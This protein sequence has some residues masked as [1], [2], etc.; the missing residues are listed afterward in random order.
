MKSI[1]LKAL[2]A[3][4]AVLACHTATAQTDSVI[5][6]TITHRYERFYY[7]SWYDT[8]PFFL[9]SHMILYPTL[10]I[11]PIGNKFYTPQPIAVKGLA[12]M[13]MRE[14]DLPPVS[15]YRYS[16]DHGHLPEYLSLWQDSSYYA[17]LA[18]DSLRVDTVIPRVMRIPLSGR[19]SSRYALCHLYEV[20]FD[21]PVIVDSF[22]YVGGSGYSNK[23]VPNDSHTDVGPYYKRWQYATVMDVEGL[24]I[25]NIDN[26]C[27]NQSP[28]YN[29]ITVIGGPSR[30]PW[31]RRWGPFFAIA[32]FYN[33]NVESSNVSWGSADGGGRYSD[34]TTVTITATP[35][36]GYRF[37]RWNDGNTR[38][39]RTVFLTQDTHFIA[40][41]TDSIPF[42]LTANP[43]RQYNGQVT[44]GGEFWYGD[45]ATLTAIPA[46]NHRFLYWNDG[47]TANPRTV[48]VTQ[49]TLFTAYFEWI[50]QHEGITAPDGQLSIL[51]SQFSITPNP[52]RNSVTVTINPQLSILNSQLSMTLTDAAGRELLNTKVSTLNFQLPISQYPAGTYFVTLRTPDAS[53]TQRLV[54]K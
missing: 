7:Y 53:S 13:V 38:N 34:Q 54:I 20:F 22:F 3:V 8:C 35:E 2:I 6:D 33:I 37:R 25:E 32:D 5:H 19:N 12:A 9:D 18:G 40:Y 42:Q 15:Y 29:L 36:P 21:K 26:Y 31:D 23:G 17:L 51:N 24:T 41:F 27:H 50:D 30:L 16:P 44:G 10:N 52:A 39:P 45:T 48:V 14:E 28:L 11:K 1:L 43:D 47:D 49:D 46:E 4:V